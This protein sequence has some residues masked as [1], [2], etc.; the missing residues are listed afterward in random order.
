METIKISFSEWIDKLEYP[1][2]WILFNAKKRNELS[3]HKKIQKKLMC[4]LL[5][6]INQSENATYCMT[7]IVC[8]SGNDKTMETV[9]SSV[10]AKG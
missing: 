3:S 2:K 1:D 8:H 10:V 9:K 4:I 6:K 7:A 5:S